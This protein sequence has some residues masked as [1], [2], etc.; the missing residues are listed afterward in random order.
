LRNGGKSGE[1]LRSATRRRDYASPALLS[2]ASGF[3]E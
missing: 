2:L 3:S 1:F